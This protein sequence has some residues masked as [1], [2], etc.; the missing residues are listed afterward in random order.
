MAR[1][2]AIMKNKATD[3]VS[4]CHRVILPRKA[5]LRYMILSGSSLPTADNKQYR[6]GLLTKSVSDCST[7][8]PEHG[9]VIE[10]AGQKTELATSGAYI[11]KL[12]QVE[13]LFG[14]ELPRRIKYR[15]EIFAFVWNNTGGWLNFQFT[16]V[17][18]I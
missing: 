13:P 6:F 7:I 11:G 9:Y 15:P 5:K 17:Y 4:W 14:R 10:F 18:D 16:L 2:F 1:K 8:N 12:R 3:T